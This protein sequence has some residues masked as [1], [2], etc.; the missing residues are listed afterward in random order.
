MAEISLVAEAGRPSGTRA[1]KRLRRAGKIPAV[2][3]GHGSDPVPVAVD[4]RDLRHA[5]NSDAGVNALLNLTIDGKEHL[6]MAKS[7]QRDPVRRNVTHVDFLIVSRD[8]VIE[9]DVPFQLVGEAKAVHNADGVVEQALFSLTVHAT[10][11]A[12]P[13][14]IE[15]DV[16]GLTIGDAIRVGDLKL[17]A[18]VTTET[19]PEEAIVVGQGAQVS[20]L[21]LIS[22]ADAEGLRELAEAQAAEAEAEGEGEGEGGEGAA[23]TGT[24]AG[25]GSASEQPE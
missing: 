1:A 6:T 16:S 24:A 25:V 2:V 5:L 10:P 8:E 11:A 3:Y 15:V 14:H 4:A 19:D 21:D 20:E 13:T 18:G 7:L 23:T 22:E 12:I 17:P 9:A